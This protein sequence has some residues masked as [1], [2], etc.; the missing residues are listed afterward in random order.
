MGDDKEKNSVSTA[1]ASTKV[2]FDSKALNGLR[3]FAAVHIVIHHGFQMSNKLVMY[4][5]VSELT[6]GACYILIANQKL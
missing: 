4:G 6:C 3:G 2:G 5:N 1:N